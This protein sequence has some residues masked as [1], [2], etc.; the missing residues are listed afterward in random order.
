MDY[1]EALVESSGFYEPFF[2]RG[3]YMVTNHEKPNFC[4]DLFE[5]KLLASWDYLGHQTIKDLKTQ[6]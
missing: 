1:T 4:K 3:I 2:F 6:P 5:K